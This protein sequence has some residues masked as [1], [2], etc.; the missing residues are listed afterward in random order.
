[1]KSWIPTLVYLLD[2]VASPLLLTCFGLHEARLE[3]S[4]LKA[5][6]ANFI[7]HCEGNFGHV[8]EADKPLSICNAMFTWVQ[9]SKFNKEH[10]KMAKEAVEKQLEA[11]QLFQ[12]LKEVR[13]HLRILSDPSGSA[14]TA[15]AEM[16]D[17]RFI[18]ALKTAL[19]EDDDEN[20]GIQQ[21]VR[22]AMK[23][24]V[25]ACEVPCAAR[26]FRYLGLDALRRFKDWAAT[27][28]WTRHDWV[29]TEVLDW[30]EGAFHILHETPAFASLEAMSEDQAEI[31][32]AARLEVRRSCQLLAAPSQRSK[33]VST[34]GKG[35]TLHAQALKGLWV[36]I[37]SRE[38]SCWLHGYSED[39]GHACDITYWDFTPMPLPGKR[40]HMQTWEIS[41]ETRSLMV[42][43]CCAISGKWSHRLGRER[44]GPNLR[45][46]A[47]CMQGDK[48]PQRREDNH[49]KQ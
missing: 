21:I 46:F 41:K 33:V 15:W 24:V 2:N 29:R 5:L 32:F 27:A 42:L 30:V 22:C 7:Q 34:L 16:Y 1:M 14:R 47:V 45:K 6:E 31:P 3:N 17:G 13:S 48:A 36:K 8:L 9:G 38:Q 37:V 11:C 49:E 10:L 35:H 43:Q 18:P 26:L 44:I 4:L 39:D 19:E 12:F 20:G 28:Q 23:T 40:W 25:A